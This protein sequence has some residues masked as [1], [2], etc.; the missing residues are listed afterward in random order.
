MDNNVVWKP[1][2]DYEGYYEVSSNGEIRSCSRYV[3]NRNG[4]VAGRIMQQTFGCSGYLQVGLCKDGKKKIV[5]Y[6]RLL[7]AYLSQTQKTNLVSTI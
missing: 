5:R 7:R 4:F 2:P 6:I 3:N 1:I